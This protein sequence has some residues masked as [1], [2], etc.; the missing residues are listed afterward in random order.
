VG[1]MV[2]PNQPLRAR[3]MPLAELREMVDRIASGDTEPLRDKPTAYAANLERRYALPAAPAL[4]ALVGVPLGMQRKRGA[5]SYGA[6]LCALLAFGYYALQSLCESL[7]TEKGFPPRI[8][9]WLP[10]AAFAAAGI[11]LLA[12]TRRSS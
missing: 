10:N 11:A 9:M 4:F 3:E 6:I 8:A 2:N 5:R 7:A 1:Q 12:R